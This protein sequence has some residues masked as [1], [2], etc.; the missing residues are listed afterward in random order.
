METD[1]HIELGNATRLRM[2]LFKDNPYVKSA[3]DGTP[4]IDIQGLDAN[5]MPIS[6]NLNDI[7]VGIIIGMSGDYFGGREVAYE[8]PM[9]NDFKRNKATFNRDG[10]CETLGQLLNKMPITEEQAHKLVCSYKRF[11]NEDVTQ[12]D[13]NTILTIN[14]A[15]YIPF[16]STLNSYVQQLMF[17][18]RVNNYSEILNRNLSHFTPWSVRAY[19]IGHHLA[20]QYARL[21]YELKQLAD[22]SDYQSDNEEFN[23]IRGILENTPNGLAT[24]NV[25]DLSYRY[26]ALSLSMEY[27][28]FHYY[29]DHFAAGH[30]A[31]MGDLRAILPERF[32][33]L[34]SI[35]VN[36]LHDELNRVAVYTKK[37]YDPTPNPEDPPVIAGGDGDFDAP[38]NHFNKLAC[39]AGMQSSLE[40]LNKVFIGEAIPRQNQYGGFESMPDIDDNYRQPQP[41]II[42][43]EDNKV[44]RRTHVSEIKTLSPSQLK[45]ALADPENNGYTELSNKWDAFRLV[46]K[47]RILPFFYEG[48]LL[49]LTSTQLQ[50]IVEE[51]TI[52]NPGRAPIPTPQ[53][54]FPVQIPVATQ[55]AW[56]IPA[57]RATVSEGLRRNSIL[58]TDTSAR[59]PSVDVELELATE[60][61][62]AM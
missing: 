55:P 2:E 50:T 30:G 40:D 20:L 25:Q 8:L 45:A 39:I 23:R 5:G 4:L 35:L 7:P 60:P 59:I 52:L 21:S 12:K 44:Y 22:N 37:P 11:A 31:F 10:S 48:K 24:E 51:E 17:A 41:L 47:L 46:F 32:G 18:L 29:T 3:P 16:S 62:M 53:T 14:S 43:G 28:C 6:I 1:E 42:L 19:T 54:A 33:T 34:G 9:I 36:N 26:Q 49:P 57:T 58:A 56:Q 27:F 15:S 13:I 38:N 61:S